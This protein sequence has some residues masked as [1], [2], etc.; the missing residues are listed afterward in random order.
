ME[1][2]ERLE[3]NIGAADLELNAAELA[4]LEA[5][6]PNGGIG[7]RYGDYKLQAAESASQPAGVAQA[8]EPA[9]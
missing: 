9:P 8:G 5:V 4:E 7:D 6:L 2:R 3:E 1:L